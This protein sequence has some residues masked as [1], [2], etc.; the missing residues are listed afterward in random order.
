MPH[1]PLSPE[2]FTHLITVNRKESNAPL[3]SRAFTYWGT[4]LPYC[5]SWL[6]MPGFWHKKK[7]AQHSDS[8]GTKIKIYHVHMAKKC[9]WPVDLSIIYLLH[10]FLYHIFV[11]WTLKVVVIDIFVCAGTD[12]Y[13]FL[14]ELSWLSARPASQ[15]IAVSIIETLSQQI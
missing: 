5:L 1:P 13:V 9:L 4:C 12:R 8:K 14:N 2:T 11:S 7:M 6:L 10:I 3:L 15:T